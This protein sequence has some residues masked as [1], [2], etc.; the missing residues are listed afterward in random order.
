MSN[1]SGKRLVDKRIILKLTELYNNGP[2]Y[3]AI[4][5][6][7]TLGIIIVAVQIIIE[8]DNKYKE[9]KIKTRI[10]QKIVKILKNLCS[11]KK[12]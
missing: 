10:H 2:C 5:L 1:H 6:T 9:N 11:R 4:F 8:F 7:S 12:M 3:S